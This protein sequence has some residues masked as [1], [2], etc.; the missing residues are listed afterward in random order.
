MPDG[1]TH[2]ACLTLAAL[3][4]ELHGNVWRHRLDQ[5]SLDAIVAATTHLRTV[6]GC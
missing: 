6:L 3:L 1:R 4:E 5:A 2:I